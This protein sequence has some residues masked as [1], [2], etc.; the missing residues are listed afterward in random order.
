MN[1]IFFSKQIEFRRWL[2]KNHRKEKEIYVGFYKTKSGK[3]SITWPQSV[4]EALCFGWIDGARKSI[5]DKSYYIRF[6]PRKPGSIWSGINIKK[7][8]ELT[9]LGLMKPSG[10]DAFKKRQEQK[11][12]IYSYENKMVKLDEAYQRKFMLN[13]KAW[14]FFNAQPV[15]YRKPAL[16]WVMRAKQEATRIKRLNTL[17]ED[18]KEGLRV[19]HLRP[20]KKLN[21]QDCLLRLS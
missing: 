5:D 10:I 9:K 11:S 4:D 15:S 1:P 6:T 16:N 2:Q 20:I 17:I 18:S 7:I 14:A 8:A 19:K 12:K 21:K 3:K 13:K